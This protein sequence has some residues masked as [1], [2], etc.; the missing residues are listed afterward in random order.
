MESRIGLSCSRA[1]RNASSP[2]GNQSTGFILSE[3]APDGK[4]IYDGRF[5]EEDFDAVYRELEDRYYASEGAEYAEQGRLSVRFLAAMD[6][7]DVEA[8]RRVCLPTFRW[9]TP[10]ST[11]V[12]QERSLDEFFRWLRERADQVSSVRNFCS[13]I[14]WLSPECFVALGDVQAQGSNN[15]EYT[16]AR[17]YVGE[18]RDGLLAS[19]RQFD[20][21]AAA[22]NYAEARIPAS[23]SRLAVTNRATQTLDRVINAML[24]PIT[25]PETTNDFYSQQFAYD[26]R[27]RFSGDGHR[28]RQRR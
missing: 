21:E 5:D 2:H 25:P 15:E 8:A 12:V 27:R 9:F 1:Q 22:F 23:T 24:D 16:W 10:P 13:V 28:Q 14:R 3:I 4:A 11:L 19:M 26:D 6:S 7:L 20:D 18:L 17:I